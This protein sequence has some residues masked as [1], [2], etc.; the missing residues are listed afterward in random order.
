MNKEL[1][2]ITTSV[3]PRCQEAKRILDNNNIEYRVM[4]ADT[5][6]YGR[7]FAFNH[8]VRKVPQL[9]EK[10]G[11]NVTFLDMTQDIEHILENYKKLGRV[12]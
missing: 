1:I 8:S 9:I 3:C 4:E 12:A 6:E 5:E 7:E 10:N 11:E 2:L